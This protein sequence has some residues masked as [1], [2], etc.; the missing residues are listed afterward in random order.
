MQ[1]TNESENAVQVKGKINYFV[2]CAVFGIDNQELARLSLD[3]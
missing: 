1:R 2:E 3:S